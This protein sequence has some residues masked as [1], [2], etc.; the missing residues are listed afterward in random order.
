MD[1]YSILLVDDEQNILNSLRR[2]LLDED[3]RILTAPGGS[4]ALAMLA[5]G[6]RPAVIVSDQRMPGMEGSEFLARARELAPESVR[7]MLT[8]YADI[9]AAVDAVNR[10]GISRYVTKPWNDHELRL[11]I[12]EALKSY[13]LIRENRRLTAELQ[14]KNRLLEELNEDLERKVEERTRDLLRKMKELE[15][16]DRIQQLL[17][18]VHPLEEVLQTVLEVIIGVTGVHTAAVHLL[19]T[20]DALKTAAA[21]ELRNQEAVKAEAGR[22]L[23]PELEKIFRSVLRKNEPLLSRV[24]ASGKGKPVPGR[25]V[26]PVF[27]GGQPLAV[28]EVQKRDPFTGEDLQAV[29]SYGMQAAIAISDARLKASLPSSEADLDEF[30][31]SL[32]D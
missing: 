29:L 7:I 24:G 16:R 32:K 4:E 1:D 2:L 28:I 31:R 3:C 15:G 19:E 25:A 17:L 9:G 21:A 6:E 18:T 11:I 12:R 10:G 8:G 30:L 26:V 14:E 27:K 13:G 20:D 23:P 22:P 5:G